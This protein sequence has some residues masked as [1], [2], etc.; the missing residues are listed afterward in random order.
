M[1]GNFSDLIPVK[2]HNDKFLNFYLLCLS[3]SEAT[4]IDHS[5]TRYSI[6]DL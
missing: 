4:D 3:K 1:V 6:I 5:E 2:G